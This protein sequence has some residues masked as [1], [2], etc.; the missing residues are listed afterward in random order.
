MNEAN[1]RI[2]FIIGYIYEYENFGTA[3]S[4]WLPVHPT[5][6]S[7]MLDVALGNITIVNRIPEISSFMSIPSSECLQYSYGECHQT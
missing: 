4:D 5:A 7:A 1:K 3:S 2:E 6:G